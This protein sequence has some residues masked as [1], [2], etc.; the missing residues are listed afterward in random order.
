VITQN[1][2]GCN[3]GITSSSSQ[4]VNNSGD[5]SGDYHPEELEPVEEWD[6][7]E[8][9]ISIVIKRW[10]EHDDERDNQQKQEPAAILV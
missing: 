1:M 7:E 8:L 3:H 2:S 4:K 6:I 10:P 5:Y 9:W